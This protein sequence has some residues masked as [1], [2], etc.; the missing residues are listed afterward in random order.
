MLQQD[1]CFLEGREPPINA[2]PTHP[3]PLLA[4]PARCPL[5]GRWQTSRC[6]AGSAPAEPGSGRRQ[7][8]FSCCHHL[9]LVQLTKGQVLPGQE[10][11][12]CSQLGSTGSSQNTTFDGCKTVVHQQPPSSHHEPPQVLG[13]WPRNVQARAAPHGCVRCEHAV[14]VKHEDGLGG[15]LRI[16]QQPA[17]LI[18]PIPGPRMPPRFGWVGL[19]AL[20]RVVHLLLPAVA[21]GEWHHIGVAVCAAAAAMR[22]TSKA[23]LQ[24]RL[25][26]LR[27][28][29]LPGPGLPLLL[30]ATGR[31]GQWCPALVRPP[32]AAGC[33]CP[34]GV[35]PPLLLL[36]GCR[37]P[38]VH[39]S[40]RDAQLPCWL[41]CWAR[42][43]AGGQVG[44]Q[45]LCQHLRL[46]GRARHIDGIK[47]LVDSGV[48]P[49]RLEAVDDC[50]RISCGQSG[51]PTACH[52]PL[53]AQLCW[54]LK[55]KC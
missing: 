15:G 36:V 13:A 14:G 55:A 46:R 34:R 20:L 7:G 17:G 31:R 32:P 11:E 1:C 4:A 8:T 24:R 30:L 26:L 3:P 12:S 35:L 29:L 37:R 33:I 18:R 27:L 45:L 54:K 2:S 40:R 48:L 51:M 49:L 44:Q 50:R 52:C 10:Q 22:S 16:Q 25:P 38:A 9:P 21:A 5:C 19:A 53:Q 42:H 47:A 6:P 23:R 39:A 41:P 28:L 43:P